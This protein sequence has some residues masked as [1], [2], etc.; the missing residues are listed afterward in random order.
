GFWLA[1]RYWGQGLMTE[2]TEAI[3]DCAFTTLGFETLTLTNALG[4]TRSRRVKEIAGAMLLRTEPARFVDPA[5]TE[6]EVWM[7]SKAAWVARRGA[8]KGA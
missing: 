5:Y 8:K 3:T 2:A 1:R 6:Q 4:N 7:L